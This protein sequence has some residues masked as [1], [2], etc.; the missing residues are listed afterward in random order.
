MDTSS[1]FGNVL[2]R[3]LAV[4]AGEEV[5]LLTDDG[6][7]HEVV[8]ALVDGIESRGAAA[9]VS[10]MPMPPL[11]GS[12]PPSAIAAAMREAGAVI[13]LTSLFIGSSSARR[14][15]T[16]AGVRYLAMPGVR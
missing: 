15:A 3:C 10:R 1:G 14:Q 11:P 6:T 5:M 8:A 4:R 12:E 9:I 2:D 7:D 16:A 13:E